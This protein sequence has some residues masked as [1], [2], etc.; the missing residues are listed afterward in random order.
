[1]KGDKLTIVEVLLVGKHQQQAVLH[2]P[3]VDDTV[4]FLSCFLHALLVGRIDHE[5]ETLGACMQNH[6]QSQS[7]HTHGQL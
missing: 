4:Q 1:M 6:G 2:L 3:V 7:T 5:D